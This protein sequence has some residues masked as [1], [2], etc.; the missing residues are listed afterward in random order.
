MERASNPHSLWHF[1]R[2]QTLADG[3]SG[4]DANRLDQ[5]LDR[6]GGRAMLASRTERA[7]TRKDN[8]LVLA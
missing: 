4:A 2:A 6:T 7:L 5:L 3:L 1:S 8:V